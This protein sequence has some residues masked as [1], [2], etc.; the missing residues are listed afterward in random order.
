MRHYLFGYGSLINRESRLVT[1][2]TGEA[3]PVRVSGL[4]RAWNIVAPE[5]GISGVGVVVEKSARC[6]GVLV[7]IDASQLPA[8]DKRELDDTNFS[9]QRVQILT[10]DI[11]GLTS[12]F[13]E[14]SRVWA[15]VVQK[16]STPS[17]KFPIAQ[18][19]VD[20]ILTGC[21][22]FGEDFTVEFICSTLGWDRPWHDDRT[23]PRYIRR[24]L[25]LEFHAEIDRLLARYVPS[26]FANRRP[27]AVS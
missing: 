27:E 18:S 15:Y 10:S 24:L 1:S 20:V 8:F 5:M 11:T 16:P 7:E 13:D 21:L 12:G 4:Q 9:Y 3:V 22:A 6:N 2:C 26:A 17:E 25:K 23:H 19:Y 14:V